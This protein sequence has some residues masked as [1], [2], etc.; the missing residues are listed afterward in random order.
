[1]APKEL[2]K[3]SVLTAPSEAL[4]VLPLA[5]PAMA[6]ETNPDVVVRDFDAQL[7]SAEEFITKEATYTTQ[8]CYT[9]SST[10]TRDE[11]IA[12]LAI[13]SIE[14]DDLKDDEE[15]RRYEERL[16][17]ANA[18]DAIFELFLPVTCK[19]PT[20]GKYWGALVDILGVCMHRLFRNGI[21]LTSIVFSNRRLI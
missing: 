16:E 21:T 17:V 3:E 14:V 10:S 18:L 19:G 4:H 5:N 20:T 13:Q 1:M 2:G 15:K 9:A 11:V 12:K 7:K 8:L 6:T